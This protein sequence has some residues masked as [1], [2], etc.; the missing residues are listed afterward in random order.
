MLRQSNWWALHWIEISFFLPSVLNFN[1]FTY[2]KELRNNVQS[3]ELGIW[4]DILSCINIINPR[5]QMRRFSFILVVL[6]TFFGKTSF[7]QL[8]S[9]GW[10]THYPAVDERKIIETKWK[11]TYAIHLE[12]NTT[13]HKAE[14]FYDYFLHFRYNYSYQQYLNGR[15]TKGRVYSTQ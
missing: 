2:W 6:C 8:D 3:Q 10:G 9:L 1:D 14:R 7:A 11:Y 12:S 13:I 4:F 5:R 15:L